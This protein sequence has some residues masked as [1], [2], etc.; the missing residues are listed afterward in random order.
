MKIWKSSCLLIAVLAIVVGGWNAQLHAQV[1]QLPSVR[2][3]SYSGSAWVPD[4]GTTSLGG[5]NYGASSSIGRGFGPYGPRAI[6]SS[7]G[8]SSVSVTAQIID[9]KALDEAILNSNVPTRDANTNSVIVSVDSPANNGRRYLTG[10]DAGKPIPRAVTPK[11]PNAYRLAM[12]GYDFGP[13]QAADVPQI[14][15]DIRFYLAEGKKAESAGRIQ[16]AR[17]YYRMAMQALTPEIKARYAKI[18][19]QQKVAEKKRKEANRPDRI[20]F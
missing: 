14:E 17:V 19:E 12:G 3:F 4:G 13:R 10:T 16:S 5:V 8:G 15:D 11:D 20:K 18:L 1:V 6:G 9:L 2:N 7:R